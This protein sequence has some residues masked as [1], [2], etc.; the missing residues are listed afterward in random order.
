MTTKRLYCQKLHLISLL[1][2]FSPINMYYSGLTKTM[3][4]WY[5]FSHHHTGQPVI[6]SHESC[7]IRTSVRDR[8]FAQCRRFVNPERYTHFSGSLV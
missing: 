3:L 8:H 1:D 7:R 4:S 2:M 5:D 6:R